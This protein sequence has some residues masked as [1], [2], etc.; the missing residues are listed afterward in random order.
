M[1]ALELKRV[2]TGCEIGLKLRCCN[3]TRINVK[4]FIW[5]DKKKSTTQGQDGRQQLGETFK[6]EDLGDFVTSDYACSL[7]HE[8]VNKAKD[9]VGPGQM[10][11]TVWGKAESLLTDRGRGWWPRIQKW[12]G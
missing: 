6:S 1:R 3:I 12:S 10:R 7:Q 5:V 9:S 8:E 2:L 11:E 4:S